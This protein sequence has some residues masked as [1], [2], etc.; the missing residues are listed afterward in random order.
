MSYQGHTYGFSRKN[1]LGG[2]FSR[3][4]YQTQHMSGKGVGTMEKARDMVLGMVHTL[5]LI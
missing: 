2:L 4:S 3:S 5:L 1:G